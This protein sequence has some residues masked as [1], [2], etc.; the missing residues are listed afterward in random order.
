M[1]SAYNRKPNLI[2]GNG[3]ANHLES[4]K[5]TISTFSIDGGWF[6]AVIGDGLRFGD[7]R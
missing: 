1:Y 3:D 2:D 7:R 5:N 4:F 6:D